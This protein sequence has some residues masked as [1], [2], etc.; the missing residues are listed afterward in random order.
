MNCSVSEEYYNLNIGIRKA[1]KNFEANIYRFDTNLNKLQFSSKL[2]VF[3]S[4]ETEREESVAV[5][6]ALFLVTMLLPPT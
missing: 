4:T 1:D 3:T 5:T 6:D 2:D